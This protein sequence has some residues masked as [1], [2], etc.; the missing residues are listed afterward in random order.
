MKNLWPP[1]RMPYIVDKAGKT[2]SCLFEAAGAGGA[3]K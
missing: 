1:W 2:E 3:Y